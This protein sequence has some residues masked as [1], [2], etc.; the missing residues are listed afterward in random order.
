MAF[1][2]APGQEPTALVQR[3]IRRSRAAQYWVVVSSSPSCAAV[4]AC[5][6]FM[7]GSDVMIASTSVE[8]RRLSHSS[9]SSMFLWLLFSSS[10]SNLWPGL[11][12]R[13]WFAEVGQGG[14]VWFASLMRSQGIFGDYQ[15]MT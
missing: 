6:P 3:R 2:R 8:V 9:Y 15:G 7:P 13:L 1:S 14:L 5:L 11:E 12:R 10:P 4:K